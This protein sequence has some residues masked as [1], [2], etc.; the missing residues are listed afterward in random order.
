MTP[1]PPTR[2]DKPRYT[3]NNDYLRNLIRIAL[4]CAHYS[5]ELQLETLGELWKVLVDLGWTSISC[6]SCRA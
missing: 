2:I 6:L 3:A 1:S 4:T 5:S